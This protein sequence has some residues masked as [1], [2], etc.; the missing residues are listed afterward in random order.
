MLRDII[1]GYLFV[2]VIIYIGGMLNYH[3]NNLPTTKHYTQ[4]WVFI[5]DMIRFV[6]CVCF[7]LVMV[8]DKESDVYLEFQPLNKKPSGRL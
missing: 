4:P 5:H 6:L 3:H 2:G 8:L 7:W 1:I